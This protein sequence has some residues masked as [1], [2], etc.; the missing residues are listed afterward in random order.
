MKRP[1]RETE[2]ARK[3]ACASRDDEKKN[4]RWSRVPKCYGRW[5]DGSASPRVC[6]RF[7]GARDARKIATRRA[8]SRGARAVHRVFLEA[9][10]FHGS[11]ADASIGGDVFSRG[12]GPRGIGGGGNAPHDVRVDAPG[13]TQHQ[14]ELR[15]VGLHHRDARAVTHR[16]LSPP[17]EAAVSRLP[18]APR[19]KALVSSQRA[20][21]EKKA[22]IKPTS[23]DAR[24]STF[25]TST[26][27]VLH[28]TCQPRGP[29]KD[30][31]RGGM[32][33]VPS[34]PRRVGEALSGA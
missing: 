4:H 14:V 25:E 15:L 8:G 12:A 7:A 9:V 32:A 29:Q 28:R 21:R 11:S 6:R 23:D 10:A 26:R 17:R 3:V 22:K 33:P 20:R 31:T 13:R 16:A 5:D 34:P 19:Q 27:A 24:R 1:I 18:D 2:R 30:A